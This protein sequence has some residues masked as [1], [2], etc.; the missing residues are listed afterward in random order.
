MFLKCVVLTLG[1]GF[2]SHFSKLTFLYFFHGH[3]MLLAIAE[4]LVFAQL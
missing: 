2:D 4:L 3:A 1:C